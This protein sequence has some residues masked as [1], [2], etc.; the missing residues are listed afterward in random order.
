M[1]SGTQTCKTMTH[2]LSP[3]PMHKAGMGVSFTYPTKC[4]GHLLELCNALI[5]PGL[6]GRPSSIPQIFQGFTHS[7][8]IYSEACWVLSSRNPDATK[9][10]SVLKAQREQ[11]LIKLSYK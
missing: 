11:T 3:N 10:T 5:T 1:C 9:L 4:E 2:H 6:L 7:E 8:K